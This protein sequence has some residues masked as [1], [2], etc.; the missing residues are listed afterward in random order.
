MHLALPKEYV[1]RYLP[2]MFAVIA[3]GFVGTL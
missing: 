1:G 2:L 3:A